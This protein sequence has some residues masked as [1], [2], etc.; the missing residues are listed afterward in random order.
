MPFFKAVQSDPFYKHF[1][2][3]SLEGYLSSHPST[4]NIYRELDADLVWVFVWCMQVNPIH[5]PST[6][7]LLQHTFVAAAQGNLT[8]DM[9]EFMQSVLLS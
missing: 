4:R 9:R 8:D 6:E 2:E 5:R 1:H 3:E 7:E